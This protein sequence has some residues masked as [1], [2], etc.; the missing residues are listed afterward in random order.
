MINSQM[1]NSDQL[2]REV[3]YLFSVQSGALKCLYYNIIVTMNL[4]NTVERVRSAKSTPV[5]TVNE[6]GHFPPTYN[7]D[8]RFYDK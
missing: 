2:T 7:I 8:V 4:T 3:L 1:K 5:K 6:F